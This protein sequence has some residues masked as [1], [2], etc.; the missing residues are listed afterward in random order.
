MV[1]LVLLWAGA[2]VSA[3]PAA[4]DHVLCDSGPP[5][6]EGQEYNVIVWKNNSN[7]RGVG[8]WGPGMWVGNASHLNVPCERVSSIFVLDNAN[9]YV[10]L[11]WYEIPVGINCTNPPPA[12]DQ[13]RMLVLYRSSGQDH[14]LGN[15]IT[16]AD[17]WHSF[18][19]D[20]AN[21]NGVFDYY[22]NGGFVTNSAN[23]LFGTG[24]NLVNTERMS[25]G[26]AWGEFKTVFYQSGSGWF[27]WASSGQWCDSDP[28]YMRYLLAPNWVKIDNGVNGIVYCPG[29]EDPL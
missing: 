21:A 15:G 22:H 18:R 2:L 8:T 29:P 6:T 4:A 17:D 24:L 19:I 3:P 7:H 14:C 12:D 9:N 23:M 28:G 1:T 10:E 16:L 27:D 11:G 5:P 25:A 13:P 26:I 20:N